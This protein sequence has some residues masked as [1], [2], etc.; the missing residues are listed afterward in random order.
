MLTPLKKG[1][2]L[3]VGALV[4]L[5]VAFFAW[6]AAQPGPPAVVPAPA[7]SAS[8]V[9]TLR[10][11]L[12][13]AAGSALHAAA[14]RFAEQVG[15]RSQGKLKVSVFPDQQLGSDDQML[16][17]TRDGT[18]DLVLM[19]TAKLSS[20][21]PAMQYADLPFYFSG[22]EELHAMLDGEPGQLLLAK[23]GGIDLVGLGFWDNG[24]KQFTANMPLRKPEDFAKLRIRTMKSAL[25]ADQFATLGAQPIPID[26]HATYQALKDG[27]VDGEENPLVAIVGMRFHEVQKHLTISNHAYLGYVFA[28]SKRVFET[29]S[30]AMREILQGTARELTAWEREETAR[31]ESEFLAAIRA[32]GVE[33]YTLTPQERARFAAVLA[34]IADKFGFAVGYDLLAKTEE[35]RHQQQA[36]R[37]SGGAVPLLIGLDADLSARGAQGGGAIFR[38]IQLA[39]EEINAKGGLLGAPLR[40]IARDN[41]ANAH[42]GRRNVAHFAALPGLLAV[43]GG[44]HTAVIVE[45]LDDIHRLKLPYLIPWAAGQTL[46]A[47]EYRPSYTFRVSINDRDVAPFLLERALKVGGHVSILLERSAWGRS[48]EAALLPLLQQLPAGRA[49]IEWINVADPGIAARIAALANGNTHALLLVTNAAESRVIVNA[50]AQQ[51]K[52]LPIFAHWGLTGADFWGQTQAALR[53]VDL[54]FVQTALMD[55]HANPRLKHFTASYRTRF[56]LDGDTPIPSPLGS[57]NAYDLTH[58]LARAVARAKTTE[59]AA[60]RNALESLPNHAG[61]LREYAPAFSPERHDA[62]DRGTLRLARFDEGGRIVAAD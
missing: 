15:E 1:L 28:A 61:V 36:A 4:L 48:S 2:A 37:A 24:F 29:L 33:I 43:V 57:A 12:N 23:L 39:V 34:P 42:I 20:A 58:L 49:E 35:L 3:V 18:L 60:I 13:I 14:L 10:L 22:R 54:R 38:G 51:P 31:R 41:G 17:M 19:P 52:P 45:E 46:T 47:H 26:F 59:R 11:G 53:T 6:R 30:P 27:A 7:S 44:M 55:D 62:L 50:M 56:G 32:A 25:I 5:A 21:I 16:E 9:R 40:L 8:D